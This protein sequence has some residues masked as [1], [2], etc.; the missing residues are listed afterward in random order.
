LQQYAGPPQSW[1]TGLVLKTKILRI[2]VW[3]FVLC[4]CTYAILGRL[5]EDTQKMI[6]A[7]VELIMKT[8]L[9]LGK[10]GGGNSVLALKGADDDKD[11]KGDGN[12]DDEDLGALIG[13]SSFMSTCARKVSVVGLPLVCLDGVSSFFCGL[14]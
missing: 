10:H 14:L 2:L 6:A 7:G 13:W 11:D 1:E 3:D 12:R 9:L 5:P 4:M 8:A